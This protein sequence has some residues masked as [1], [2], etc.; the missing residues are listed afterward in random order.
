[1]S[2]AGRLIGSG[3][4]ILGYPQR[5]VHDI[6]NLRRGFKKFF[7]GEGTPPESYQSL[8]RLF[9]STQGRSS[10]F[11]HYLIK[12]RFPPRKLDHCRGILRTES[13]TDIRLIANEIREKGYYIVENALSPKMTTYLYDFGLNTPARLRPM[14]SANYVGPE[15]REKIDLNNFK[16]VRYDILEED[17]IN[18]AVVQE[19][20]TDRSLLSLG[21]EYLGCLPRA[22]V[23]GM[24]WHTDFSTQA[25]DEAATM[26]H[27]DMDRVKWLKFFV[28][29]TDVNTDSG[30][31]CFIERT[32]RSGQIPKKLLNRGYARIQ[33][34][35]AAEC[36]QPERFREFIAKKGT[37]IIEDTRGLHK[38]KPVLKGH[39]LLFQFQLSD[40]IFGGYY[41]ETLMKRFS[42]AETEKFITSHRDIYSRFLK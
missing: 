32:H 30:P 37:M 9:C 17:L 40:L 25:N 2:I 13:L 19:I 11:I 5:Q 3:L 26:W 39:R 1:M 33:D 34:E 18:D 16:T 36:F 38:G 8:I 6:G 35:E 15:I 7:A 24:W 14:D 29:L 42:N 22:D 23:T 10:D 4:R 28:Y 31:H 27:F 20:M 41:P 21:Q 12:K